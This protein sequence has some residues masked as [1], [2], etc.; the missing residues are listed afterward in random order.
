M[1]AIFVL[2]L[3][4]L[5]AGALFAFLIWALNTIYTDMRVKLTLLQS[6]KTPAINLTIIN[7]LDDIS[8]TFTTPEVIIGRS[9]ACNFVINDETVSGQH[10]RLT[11][12]H[13]Q[14]WVEDMGS[15]NG[16]FINDERVA[17]PSVVMTGDDLRC[18]QVTI[19]LG[20]EENPETGNPGPK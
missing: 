11:F 17:M 19:H 18:G 12:H 2:I 5:L 6:R 8:A 13:E 7:T 14:W 16:T 1:S 9:L 20:I 10:A 15:T 4:I 3:R